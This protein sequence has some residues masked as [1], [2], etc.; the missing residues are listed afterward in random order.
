MTYPR[1]H[2]VDPKGGVYHV[3]SR[4]VRRAFLCGT[5][6]HSGFNFD[7]R[8]QW[9]E[10][11][12][13]L[14]SEIFA[15][16]LYGYSVMSNHYHLVVNLDPTRATGWTDDEIVERWMR[17]TPQHSTTG[18]KAKKEEIRRQ[19][20]L[21]DPARLEVLRERLCSLSWFMRYLNEPLAR[22]AN[23][24]DGCKGRFWEGRFKSQRLLD[25]NALL[26]CMVYVDLN[27]VRAGVVED[28]AEAEHTSLARRLIQAS[29]NQDNMVSL[30]Q[31][32]APL[33]FT[34]TLTEYLELARWTQSKQV[35]HPTPT[36][37]GP[38]NRSIDS[39][40]LMQYSPRPGC[41]Q[42]AIGSADNLSRYATEIGQRW[43]RR[44]A[45]RS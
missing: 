34:H 12:I 1:S 28:A 30:N 18:S 38:Q 45:M 15:I 8:K 33:P 16:D 10:S 24:E 43:I 37:Y 44:P 4:C 6:Q 26:A 21:S 31:P 9:L 3:C 17:L 7:H 22:L 13:L 11:R 14:L 35:T 41:W 25:E 39:I 20:I 27:P 2:L 36:L 5:D 42:R 29:D 32:G 23:A 40:W 19:S